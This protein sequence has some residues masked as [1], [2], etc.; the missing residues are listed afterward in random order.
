MYL[1]ANLKLDACGLDICIGGV[2]I[3]EDFTC[4]RVGEDMKV[5]LVR[6]L[7]EVALWIDG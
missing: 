2:L 7:E 5:R 4:G 6:F 3:E 1:P